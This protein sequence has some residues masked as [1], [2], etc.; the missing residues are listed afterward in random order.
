MPQSKTHLAMQSQS[1]CLDLISRIA[2][3]GAIRAI[4][5]LAAQCLVTY[6]FHFRL[7]SLPILIHNVPAVG[8]KSRVETQIKM[9]LDLAA[10]R[11]AM[12]AYDRIG[13]WK[14]LRLPKGTSTRRRPR[15]EPKIGTCTLHFS[16]I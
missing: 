4:T 11:D 13:S 5:F 6:S 1:M 10:P 8:A 12:S 15:K 7:H 16:D 2:S 3:L 14:W 9:T